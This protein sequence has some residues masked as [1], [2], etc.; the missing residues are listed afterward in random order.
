MC[1]R[2]ARSCSASGSDANQLNPYLTNAF[3]D[4]RRDPPGQR[5]LAGVDDDGE[6]IPE[7]TRRVPL[8]RERGHRPRRGRRGLHPQ[9]E[10]PADG[11]AWSDGD[12]AHPERLQV[13]LRLGGRRSAHP[14][15]SAARTA[16]SSCRSST[17]PSP[18]RSAG[19]REPARRLL[20][21]L[22]G[23]PQR[24][25]PLHDQLRGLDHDADR[26]PPHRAAVLGERAHRGDRDRC[27][28]R[29]ATRCSISPPTARSR[30]W[31]PART[32]STTSP[33]S[34]GPP[35][36]APTSI[37]HACASTA[38]RTACSRPS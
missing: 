34:S 27:H 33:T 26:D 5:P 28:G 31:P 20:R 1:P 11:L 29:V 25:H 17:R 18:T 9:P 23:R 37:R 24:S 13:E 7:L 36:P 16:R 38:P 15:R 6:F 35:T 21:G 32:A 10:A 2:V 4:F 19:R 3:K 12:A 22:R 8:C 14:A 30:S